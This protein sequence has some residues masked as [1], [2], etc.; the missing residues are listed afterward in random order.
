MTM[1]TAVDER[2]EQFK[3]DVAALGLGTTSNGSGGKGRIAGMVLMI[4]G[5][6]AAF[7]V[8]IASLTLSDLR[9]IAS[10]QLLSMGFIA[11]TLAGAAVYVA[12]VVAKVLR[13]WL[14]RQLLEGNAQTERI[15]EA[16]SRDKI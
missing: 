12:S 16:M 8:Y 9:D 2:R 10:Y 15:V 7:V 5:V 14:V 6:A 4:I 1:T 11:L 3:Q 13:L